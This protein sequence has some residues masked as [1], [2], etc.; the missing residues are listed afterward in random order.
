MDFSVK[1]DGTIGGADSQL[2]NTIRVTAEGVESKWAYNSTVN[3]NG[4]VS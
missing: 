1:F 2:A 3:I 4:V